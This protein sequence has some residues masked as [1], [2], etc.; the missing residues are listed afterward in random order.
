MYK[1]VCHIC[2]TFYICNLYEKLTL[3]NFLYHNSF[4]YLNI[5]I[6][7]IVV[8]FTHVTHLLQNTYDVDDMYY[9]GK[10]CLHMHYSN[11]TTH[12]TYITCIT[13]DTIMLLM[14]QLYY[15]Y[16]LFKILHMYCRT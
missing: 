10:A 6:V 15:K 3:S 14:L 8:F 1:H 9:T 4:Y 16:Y 12:F 7:I 13:P 11:Y 5:A 2:Y